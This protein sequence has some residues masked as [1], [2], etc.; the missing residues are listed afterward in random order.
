MATRA[1][2]TIREE[3]GD[4]GEALNQGGVEEGGGHPYARH[5]EAISQAKNA[6]QEKAQQNT[7][8]KWTQQ[9]PR[10]SGRAGLFQKQNNKADKADEAN[11]AH[12]AYE[13]DGADEADEADEANAAHDADEADGADEADEANAAHD[14]D[15]VDGADE[16]E[17]KGSCSFIATSIEIP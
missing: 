10:P 12:D 8:A 13:A 2:R 6:D 9:I 16:A 11:A 7:G 17:Y 1:A 15:E 5:L 4:R 3:M 14:A